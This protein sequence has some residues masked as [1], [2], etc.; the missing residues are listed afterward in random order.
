MPTLDDDQDQ[1][2]G[3]APRPE[4]RG[5]ESRTP[6]E[7]SQ[8]PPHEDRPEPEFRYQEE[9]RNNANLPGPSFPSELD[10]IIDEEE[11]E[12]EEERE[13]MGFFDHLEELRSRIIKSLIALACTAAVCGYFYK[14]IIRDI[15]LKPAVS[16]KLPLIN[17]EPMGQFTLAIQVVLISGLIVAIPFIIWQFWGF[18]KPGLYQKERRY[19]SVIAGATIVCF[20]TGVAFA[21]FVMIPTSITFIG[22]FQLGG[23]NN[24]IAISG[25]FS[26]ILGFILA[27]GVVFEMPMLSYALSRFGIT[28]PAMLRKYRRHAIIVILIAAA[29]ITPT[30]DPFNQL[31]LAVPLYALYE[32]SILVAATASRQRTEALE[33]SA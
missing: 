21:Y 25:Y 3:G 24:Q 28:T 30:P 9:Q 2:Y 10:P 31:L 23:I 6:G 19:V 16:A 18:V 11:F 1:T 4:H 27:C 32:I 26:F 8:Y 5:D 29:I 14:E 12:E 13:G 7:P 22:G 15:L 17:T 33:E 20:L